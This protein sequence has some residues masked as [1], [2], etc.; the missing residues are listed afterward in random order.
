MREPKALAEV[1]GIPIIVRL[2][3]TLTILDPHPAVVV[4]PKGNRPIE[5]CLRR[6][7]LQA[8]LLIQEAPLGMGDAVLRLKHSKEYPSIRDVLVVWG[9]QPFVQITT[10][11]RL[12]TLFHEQGHVMAFP[13]LLSDNCYTVVERDSE[14]RLLNLRERREV[15]PTLPLE[16]ERDTGIFLFKKEPVIETLGSNSEHLIGQTTGESGFLPVVG[17]LV[18]RGMSVEAY[19]IASDMDVQGFNTPEELRRMSEC[20][21]PREPCAADPGERRKTKC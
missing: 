6:H 15:G 20:G 7:D 5:V 16:G 1:A 10:L 2:I 8:E 3:R 9:D 14:G 21:T 4:S 17:I 13:S 11:Q 12:L 18:S 19:P